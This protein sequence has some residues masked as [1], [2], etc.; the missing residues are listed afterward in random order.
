M[1]PRL[2]KGLGGGALV[3]AGV[4]RC[5][6]SARIRLAIELLEQHGAAFRRTARR[7][8]I[9]AD[10]ADDAYQRATVILIEKAPA[11][12]SAR[13]AAWMHVVTKREALA[14]RRERERILGGELTD[15]VEAG[16]P[17]PAERAQRLEGARL[18]ARALRRLKPDERR[19]LVLR[20]EG[21]SYAEICEMT[22][23][24]YTKTNR[25]L[26]E[27]RARLR[28]LGAYD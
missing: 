13:L 14:V 16:S 5:V 10:D 28:Q 19:A 24:T 4:V 17:C 22:D 6:D 15:A 18:K 23:W 27:G 25:C 2:D 11:H 12:P 1:H 26:A 20:G 7:V 8:S 9:C 3:V 21:Y